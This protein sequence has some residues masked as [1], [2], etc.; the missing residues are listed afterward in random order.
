MVDRKAV[1]KA[2]W[3]AVS[4]VVWSAGSMAY[5]KVDMKAV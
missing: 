5:Q 2:V 4:L 3:S 1:L